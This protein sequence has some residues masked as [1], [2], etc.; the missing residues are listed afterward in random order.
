MIKYIA[1]WLA[2][3]VRAEL[4]QLEAAVQ[5]NGQKLA[6]IERALEEQTAEL[7][8]HGAFYHDELKLHVETHVEKLKQ[9]LA[10]DAAEIAKFRKSTRMPCSFC[11]Q[12][13]WN[14]TVLAEEGKIKCLGCKK[15]A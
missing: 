6:V 5:N 12:L 3:I 7:K 15:A 13:T 11:G 2:R 8:S 14:Y 4:V 1:A 10:M 9:D